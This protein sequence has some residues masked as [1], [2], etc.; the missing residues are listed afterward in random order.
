MSDQVYKVNHSGSH[1]TVRAWW[2][3]LSIGMLDPPTW[4][5]RRRTECTYRIMI[6]SCRITVGVS[7]QEQQ[8]S[9]SPMRK[10]RPYVEDM[11][12]MYIYICNGLVKMEDLG[13]LPLPR[14]TWR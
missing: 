14:S 2:A 9:W 5:S 7:M 8:I 10:K 3:E 11:E 12:V 6:R 13:L 4:S 1:Q